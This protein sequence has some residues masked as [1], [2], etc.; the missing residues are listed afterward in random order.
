MGRARRTLGEDRIPA[1]LSGHGTQDHGHAFFLSEAHD[2]HAV[3]GGWIHHAIIYART[4]FDREVVEVLDGLRHVVDAEGRS[5]QL[6]LEG[7]G[8]RGA[9]GSPLLATATEW[10]SV[11][12]YLH[13]WHRKLRFDVADQIRRECRERGLT[14]PTSLD[15][16]AEVSVGGRSRRPIDFRRLRS[17]RGLEPP[18]RQGSFWRVRFGEP[19]AGPIALGFG[20]HFGLG[21]FG[22]VRESATRIGSP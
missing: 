4:G 22:P 14:E 21:L 7:I 9:F 6:V 15:P 18:D 11:M 16:V 17:K 12:P 8:D 20:C 5:W 2:S 19:V 3:L 10:I 13:P 1:V